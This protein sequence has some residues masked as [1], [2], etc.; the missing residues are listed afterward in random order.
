MKLKMFHIPKPR[1]YGYKPLYYVPDD[2]E[3]SYK[4]TPKKSETKV[5]NGYWQKETARLTRRKSS[6]IAIYLVIVLVL[7]Y[8]IFLS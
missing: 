8:L 1:Q 2:E 6:N 7:L 5:S 4:Q 3:L